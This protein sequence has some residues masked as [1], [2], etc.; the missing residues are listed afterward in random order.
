MAH[1]Y[2]RKGALPERGRRGA[3]WSF[4]VGLC[5]N[6]AFDAYEQKRK[7]ANLHSSERTRRTDYF[8]WYV[9]G[10]WVGSKMGCY[11]INAYDVKRRRHFVAVAVVESNFFGGNLWLPGGRI[12]CYSIRWIP[13]RGS[14]PPYSPVFTHGYGLLFCP[15]FATEG[16]NGPRRRLGLLLLLKRLQRPARDGCYRCIVHTVHAGS[17]PRRKPLLDLP[18]K[19]GAGPDSAASTTAAPAEGRGGSGAT[20]LRGSRAPRTATHHADVRAGEQIFF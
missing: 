11:W 4:M 5:K 8:C 17:R 2:G 9:Q 15:V 10:N 6:R 19:T 20:R 3:P 18:P 7:L 16:R 14:V 12:V 1:T 13:S